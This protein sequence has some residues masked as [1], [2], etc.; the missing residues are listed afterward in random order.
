MEEY[1]KVLR[2]QKV[3]KKQSLKG[4]LMVPLI[5]CTPNRWRAFIDPVTFYSWPLNGN[6]TIKMSGKCLLCITTEIECHNL[7]EESRYLNVGYWKRNQ[8]YEYLYIVSPPWSVG[9]SLSLCH[10][11]VPAKSIID[12]IVFCW[13][14]K[15]F[16]F[17]CFLS[18]FSVLFLELVAMFL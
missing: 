8:G 12:I 2:K 15:N 9:S 18:I 11:S 5:I 17:Y 4:Q 16:L 3:G 6:S 7:I 13:S 10:V 14:H 1:M